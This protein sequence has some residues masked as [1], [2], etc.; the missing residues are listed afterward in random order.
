MEKFHAWSDCGGDVLSVWP[1]ETLVDNLMIYWVTNTIGS[2]VRYYHEAKRLRPPLQ[3]DD[4]V[5]A[6]TAVVVW[7][8]D[9]ALAPRELAERLYHVRRYTV[10]P[11]GGHFPAWEVP[12]LYAEDVR[13]FAGAVLA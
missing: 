7:P 4:F 2:S 12:E 8:H 13:Q 6:P 10:F 1:R 5:R 11:R 9:L 3:A